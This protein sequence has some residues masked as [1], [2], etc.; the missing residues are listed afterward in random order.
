[1]SL[2]YQ[3]LRAVGIAL[4]GS[5]IVGALMTYWHAQD[6]ISTEMRAAIS[7][8]SRIAHNAVDDAEEI[9][10]P[11]RRLEL[12][13]ADFNG[14]RHLRAF[15]VKPD[16]ALSYESELSP[17]EEAP[18]H[19][20]EWLIGFQDLKIKVPLPDA[21]SDLGDLYLE[22][23]ARNETSELWDDIQNFLSILAVFC[24]TGAA[25]TVLTLR[26]AFQPLGAVARAFEAIGSGDYQPRMALT[27]AR[28]F[29]E[30]SR[31]F[32]QMAGRLS[33][34]EARNRKLRN[35]LETVQ[36]EERTE[37]A[38]N[39]HDDVSPL[40]FCVDVDARAIR[41]ITEP[42]K[43]DGIHSHAEAIQN[44]VAAL[45]RSVKDILSD[46]RP[47]QFHAI[48]LRD[49]IEDMVSFWQSRPDDVSFEIDVPDTGWG[50]RIDDAL[51]AIVRESVSNALKH[52]EPSTIRISINNTDDK[53]HFEIEN[54]G[55]GF[56]A[57]SEHQGFGIRGMK[58]RAVNLGGAFEIVP[59]RHG[60]GVIVRGHLDAKYSGLTDR[61][62]NEEL[63]T[64]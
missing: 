15:V 12:L 1:M 57:G 10:N 59:G 42:T 58:E 21:F 38:R 36:E 31:G 44:S 39:L 19:W 56:V 22:T 27:G 60:A 52:A 47:A 51:F 64:S 45:K 18:P 41:E 13:V 6:K 55:Q 62:D 25:A 4:L 14:D 32:N 40:L 33:D 3:L 8:G 26:R 28:E 63:V 61:N 9:V 11:Q 46:L 30:L 24:V 16:G 49:G 7:V 34:M 50:G 20:L 5:L 2:R 23:D 43:L 37:L 53:V 48:S 17:P 35:Q 54:D 29:V